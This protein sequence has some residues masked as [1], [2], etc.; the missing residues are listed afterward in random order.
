MSQKDNKNQFQI[1]SQ[2]PEQTVKLGASIGSALEGG[3]IIALTGPLGSGKTQL[4]KGIVHA[5]CAADKNSVN[6]PTF[7]IVNEYHRPDGSLDIYHIDAY[8]ITSIAEF[9]RLAFDDL[10][11]TNAV[12]LIEWA[13]KIEPV[14]KNLNV[15]H[16]RLSHAGPK[17]R[18]IKIKNLP[19]HICPKTASPS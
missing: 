5:A 7:V 17:K 11:Y 6:S 1:V 3:E 14:L 13:D 15:I 8:R 9:E 12:I 10:C 2:S 16:I 18:K 4:I 19:R